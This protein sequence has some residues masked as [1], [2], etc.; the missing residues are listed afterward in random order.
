MTLNH[1][2]PGAVLANDVFST[3]LILSD[4]DFRQFVQ[5]G[6]LAGLDMAI[7][8]N[9]YLYHTRLD[10]AENVERGVLQHFGENVLSI[11][12]YLVTDEKSSLANTR[13]GNRRELPIYFSIASRF[14][15]LIPAALF[16]TMSL[17][18]TAFG[19]FQ[20]QAVNRMEKHFNVLGA[21]S[22]AFLGT[23]A[24]L[25]GAVIGTNVVALIMSK[26]IG[27][28]LSWYTREWLP[29]VLYGP[30]AIASMLVVQFFI[31][32]LVSKRNRP[33]MERATL[34]GMSILFMFALLIMNAF[35]IGSAYLMMLA[36]L[37]VIIASVVND[38]GLIGFANIEERRVPVDSRV[39][40]LTYFITTIVPA[41]IG[42]EGL[43]SFLDLFVPLTGRMGE[44]SPAENII[45]TIVAA[46]AFLCLPMV[47][48]LAHRFGEK[49]LWQ[50]ISFWVAVT[51]AVMAI[52]ASSAVEP[53][54]KW[55]PKRLFVHQA[56]NITSGEWYM[57]V[58]SADPA[59]GFASLVNDTHALLGLPSEPPQ[60]M[61]MNEHN[62]DF[63]I[64]YP[65]SAFLTP[66]KYRMPTPAIVTEDHAGVQV[67]ALDEVLD[68][69]AGTRRLT[70]QIDHPG[71]IW[72]VVAF[73][74]D[75]LEWDLPSKPPSGYQR[76]HIKEV[77]RYGTSRWTIHLLLKLDEA[78]LAAARARGRDAQPFG[79]VIRVGPGE[80]NTA[81]AH[82]DPSRLWIDFS[83]LDEQGMWPAKKATGSKQANMQNFARMDAALQEQ[84]PE[85]D[86]MLLSIVAGVA[87]C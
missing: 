64:L 78:G 36:S 61:E 42:S 68:L 45:A 66:Y 49:R 16:R 13:Q 31:A 30:P 69:E 18:V 39:H 58:G 70:L 3:G 56:Q 22:A 4:T 46:L 14:F 21:I 74:A 57:N 8:G 52:F 77:S 38:V 60:L 17:G 85:V 28:S 84:H 26:V 5:Y 43:V 32:K 15:V 83:G 73:D 47:L 59:A 33:Y 6:G 51:A 7:V 10:V 40:Y 87:V 67:K 24:S 79:D 81:T 75:I 20:L 62:S 63:D 9:S 41:S 65:V 50:A 55:H 2:S 37:T 72:S 82:R 53:F 19:N 80:D 35:S 25:I 27:K 44:A 54:D 12:R 23:V 34:S 86:A 1:Y 11:V 71:L 29:L 48:P 76:H